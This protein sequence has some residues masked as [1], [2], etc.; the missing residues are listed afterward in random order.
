VVTPVADDGL[1]HLVP[2]ARAAALLSNAERLGLVVT[3]VP[4]VPFWKV[5]N[6]NALQTTCTTNH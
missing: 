5:H 3:F 6:F 4:K 1:H 2:E